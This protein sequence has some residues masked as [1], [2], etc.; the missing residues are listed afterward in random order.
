MIWFRLH[1]ELLHDPKVQ[2][3]SLEHFKIYINCLCY[4][5]QV[6]KDGTIGNISDV[7]FALHETE[8]SVSSAFHELTLKHLITPIETDSE[9]FHVPQW[10]KKQYKSDTSTDRVKKHRALQKRSKTVTVTPPETDTDTEPYT[11]KKED[12]KVSPKGF[13]AQDVIDL[14]NDKGL[15][16]VLKLTNGRR[17]AINRRTKEDFDELDDWG[18]YF[19]MFIDSNFLKGSSSNWKATI[20]W[21]IKP[22]NMAKV[23][24]G[25]YTNGSGEDGF[26][27]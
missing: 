18:K 21:A 2:R 16:K 24:E 4:A 15:S 5:G 19:Q 23:L 7:S 9:T 14:W 8:K 10:K 27:V 13:G 6:D 25:N 3:L 20:D 1:T 11:E 22:Q 17:Q 26:D 12:T